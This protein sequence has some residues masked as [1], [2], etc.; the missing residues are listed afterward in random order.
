MYVTIWTVCLFSFLIQVRRQLSHDMLSI[1]SQA[2]L[3]VVNNHFVSKLNKLCLQFFDHVYIFV[4]TKIYIIWGDP[5]DTWATTK[6]VVVNVHVNM[7]PQVRG[8][9]SISPVHR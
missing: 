4:V 5:T 2:A 1:A 7:E 9:G 6:S 3:G 8:N